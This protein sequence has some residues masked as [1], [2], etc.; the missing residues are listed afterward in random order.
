MGQTSKV[1]NGVNDEKKIAMRY[2]ALEAQLRQSISKKEHHEIVLE[3]EDKVT[4]MEKKAAE[5]EKRIAE[6]DKELTRM[7]A[8][9]QKTNT[10]HGKLAEVG[11]QIE[12]L[13]KAMG[14]QSRNVDSLNSKIAQGTVPSSVHQHA[15]STIS[16]LE[17]KMKGM[18]PKQDYVG[19][20][21]RYNEATQHMSRMIPSSEYDEL[22]QKVEELE[23]TISSMVPKEQFASSEAAVKELEAKLAQHVPQSIYDELVTKVVQLA[24]EV[25]G[26]APPIEEQVATAQA[27]PL[28]PTPTVPIEPN[29]S[30][31]PES[32]AQLPEAPEEVKSILAEAQVPPPTA[33]DE[34]ATPEIREVG[35]Q[36]AEIMTSGTTEKPPEPTQD[37]TTPTPDTSDS[38][39][40]KAGPEIIQV[41]P[42]A[43]AKTAE[44]ET[45]SR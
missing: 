13:S 17:E 33:P 14:A 19:L 24:E 3:F 21:K 18:V 12:V 1:E 45:Q 4:E 27:E 32:P 23:N 25:T 20:E 6:Q 42:N 10:L 7:K 35:S 8:E 9:L 15:L 39:D 2:K 37:E 36:L 40:A 34:G 31:Q 44:S 26:G 29:P 30:P 11:E 22:K 38:S 28:E 16:E 5:Q 41:T 43:P